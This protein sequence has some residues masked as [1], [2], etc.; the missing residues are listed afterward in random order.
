[1]AATR[2]PIELQDH[3]GLIIKNILSPSITTG[4]FLF[5]R[6]INSFTF[7]AFI[8]AIN[9]S[10]KHLKLFLLCCMVCMVAA[11]QE[12]FPVNGVKD[13]RSDCFAFTNAT[14]VKDPQTTLQ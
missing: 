3:L 12:T 5:P 10:M 9:F 11:A 13:I 2:S 4:I 8:L 1:M 6:K 7:I 14:I